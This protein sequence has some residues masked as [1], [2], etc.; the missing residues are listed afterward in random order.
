MAGVEQDF[1]SKASIRPGTKELFDLCAEHG[2]PTIILSAG[3]KDVIEL[4]AEAYQIKPSVILAPTIN[5][6]L[7]I[8]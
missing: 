6:Y 3:I 8:S 2:I 7:Q 5:R 4:W 1:L